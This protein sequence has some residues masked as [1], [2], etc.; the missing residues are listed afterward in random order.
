[1]SGRDLEPAGRRAPTGPLT[2]GDRERYL[3]ALREGRPKSEA[4]R[5]AGRDPRS[6][7]RLAERDEGF[8]ELV[9]VAYEEEGRDALV[10]VA[11][12]RFVDGWDEPVFHRGVQVGV[13]RKFDNTLGMFLIKQR[14]PTFRERGHLEVTGAGGGPIQIQVASAFAVDR[15]AG[16]DAAVSG[17]A[18]AERVGGGVARPGLLPPAG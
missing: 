5:L 8:G 16:R 3:V 1:M 7:A 11:R 18:A 10:A 4:A 14:D 6:F 15:P 13:V 2:E 9:R 17:D 12:N